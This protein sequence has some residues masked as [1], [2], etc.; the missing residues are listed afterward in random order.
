MTFLNS[1][2][3]PGCVGVARAYNRFGDS[4][5]EYKELYI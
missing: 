3:L 4:N 1:P 2:A 5:K